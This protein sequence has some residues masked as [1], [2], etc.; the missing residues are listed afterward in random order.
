MAHKEYIRLVPGARRAVLMVHGILG[1]PDHF[2]DLVPLVPKN[3]SVHSILLDG[4]GGPIE[5]FSGTSMNRWKAQV[6]AR[7][8]ELLSTHDQVVIAAHSMGTLFA[9]REAI[10]H[11]DRIPALFLLGSPLRVFVQPT[12]AA[13][14]V[15]LTFGFLNEQ[16]R[17]AVD[18]R[19]ELSVALEPWL[20]KYI[21]WLPRFL[22]LFGEIWQIRQLL[23]Q[24]AVPT[25]VF[26]S[27]HDELVHPSSCKD[28]QGHPHIQCTLLPDSGHFG[29][30]DTDLKLLQAR[31]RD[32]LRHIEE[33]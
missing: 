19:R 1:S 4:H 3:W 21:F 27:K 11:P 18:M 32:L 26:Q 14:A 13:N 5:G 22:E 16:D 2:R 30:G 28:F 29:Y 6:S 25:Q 10:R 20:H 31:F 7:L 23:P 17:S 24:L 15:K 9:I 12:A 8:E 33:R